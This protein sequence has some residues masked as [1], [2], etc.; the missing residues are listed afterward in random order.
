MKPHNIE[1]IIFDCDGT[2]AYSEDLNN[3]ATADILSAA[4]YPQ[5]DYDFCMNELVGKD[6]T[7][8]KKYIE[9]KENK[10]LPDDF[11]QQF[12]QL[13]LERLHGGLK[14]V[15]GAEMAVDTLSKHYKVCVAS[16][17]ER[18]NVL[19]SVRAISLY[20]YFG[21]DRIFTKSQVLRGKP[22]PDLFLF[23]AEQ[24]GV[25]PARCVVVEDSMAGVGAGLAAGMLTI[26][27]TTVSHDPEQIRKDM[28]N[29]GVVHILDSWP[30]I[31]KFIQAL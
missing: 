17:G 24:M 12:I 20:D 14:P 21:D 10:K 27:I 22:A 23:A 13:V 4:G 26:G 25:D 18:N 19:S 5:Y 16:N 1:L 3:Q 28:K 31:T 11:I 29:A 6:M 30:E 9:E 8:V 7:S 15:L 2:L